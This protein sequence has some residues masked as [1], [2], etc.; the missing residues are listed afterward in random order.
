MI[1]SLVGS[2]DTLGGVA[3]TPVRRSW[4]IFLDSENKWKLILF[5]NACSTLSRYCHSLGV[6]ELKSVFDAD[7]PDLSNFHD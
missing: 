4:C 3:P 5:G 1:L 6:T 7:P 2:F